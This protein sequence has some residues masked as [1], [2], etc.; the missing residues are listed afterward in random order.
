MLTTVSPL[1]RES[2]LY[3]IVQRQRS[4]FSAVVIVGQEVIHAADTHPGCE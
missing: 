1:V 3:S 2:V 4:L